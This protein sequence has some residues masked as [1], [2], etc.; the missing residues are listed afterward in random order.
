MIVRLLQAQ[1]R[2]PQIRHPERQS[3][4]P[5]EV[6]LKLLWRDPSACARDDRLI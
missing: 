6:T 1:S 5:V 4:D 3:R 2:V